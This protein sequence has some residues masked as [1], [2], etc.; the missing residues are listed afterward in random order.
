MKAEMRPVRLISLSVPKQTA[1]TAVYS[2]RQP[3]SSPPATA[4]FYVVYLSKKK[5]QTNIRPP[6]PKHFDFYGVVLVLGP[7]THSLGD[8]HFV[9]SETH[10]SQVQFR[11]RYHT[12]FN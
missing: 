7:C 5:K 2:D 6:K 8:S 11:L 3:P 4:A 12:L 1:E 9:F 10:V